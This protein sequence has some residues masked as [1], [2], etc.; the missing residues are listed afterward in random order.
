[1]KARRGGV[2][3]TAY[4]GKLW[5]IGGEDDVNSDLSSVEVY[6]PK[7]DTWTYAAPMVE[8]A[9]PGLGLGVISLP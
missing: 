5:A 2:A 3:L 8:H 4:M 1:M 9:G 6:D 7:E